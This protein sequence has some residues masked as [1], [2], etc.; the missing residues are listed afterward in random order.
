MHRG[1][2]CALWQFG[3]SGK[4]WDAV[5]Q[6]SS[7]CS[8][9]DLEMLMSRKRRKQIGSAA[10]VACAA[11]SV[12]QAHPYVAMDTGLL[13]TY[14]LCVQ[15]VPS[16]SDWRRDVQLGPAG[17]QRGPSELDSC[18]GCSAGAGEAAAACLRLVVPFCMHRGAMYALWQSG[19]AVLQ[20]SSN[21]RMLSLERVMS[22]K[23][24]KQI[25]SAA[26]AACAACLAHPYWATDTGLLSSY[27]L[28]VQVPSSSDQ[29]REGR[30]GAAGAQGGTSKMDSC[31]GCS[32]GARESS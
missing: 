4:F 17:A 14:L 7:N 29:G 13:N 24:R 25:G 2:V 15:D 30:S 21:C 20:Q 28:C 23:T 11:R 10:P 5:S 12:H 9:L 27:L 26:P 18:T 8:M 31:T 32:A 19:N 3:S 22:R 16:G 1:A 6:Q